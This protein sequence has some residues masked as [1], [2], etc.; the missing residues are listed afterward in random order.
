M[1]ATPPTNIRPYSLYNHLDVHGNISDLNGN[2]QQWNM[3]YSTLFG[4]KY[5]QLGSELV[6]GVAIE[7]GLIPIGIGGFNYVFG[8]SINAFGDIV[9]LATANQLSSQSIVKIY[10]WDG[11]EWKQRGVDIVGQTAGDATGFSVSL[12]DAGDRVAVGAIYAGA[13]G[14]SRVYSWNGTSWT[15]SGVDIPGEANDD[16]SGWSVMLNGSGN[17]L[18]VGAYANS[19]G[20]IGVDTGHV[21]VY[22][23]NGTSWT[24]IGSDID[25]KIIGEY[26]GYEVSFNTAGDTLAVGSP[27][28]N[29]ETGLVRI[30][31]YDGAEW[32]QFGADIIGENAAE[33]AGISVSLN[34]LG[35]RVAIGSGY[36][37]A[38]DRGSVSIY[39]WRETAWVKVG[40]DIAGI[41]A[42]GASGWRVSL[43]ALGDRV[44]IG[45]PWENISGSTPRGEI[46][47]YQWDENSWTNVET[48]TGEANETEFGYSLKSNAAG[49][50]IVCHSAN[51]VKV[52]TN[53]HKLLAYK[54]SSNLTG[55]T[56]YVDSISGSDSR[57]NT[58]PYNEHKP[59]KTIAAAI[60][61][62]T[63][64]D[65]VRVRAGSY[66]ISSSISL[67]DKSNYIYFE[68]GAAVT[69][70]STTSTDTITAAAFTCTAAATEIKNIQGHATF[71]LVGTT[72]LPKLVWLEASGSNNPVMNFQ[73]GSITSTVAVSSVFA[74]KNAT[75]L[76]VDIQGVGANSLGVNL[77]SA[78][79]VLFSVTGTSTLVVNAKWIS[80]GK[81]LKNAAI[82]GATQ[83]SNI[84]SYIQIL[85]T[86][87]TTSGIDI[88]ALSNA[89]FYITRYYH[90]GTGVACIWGND[91]IVEK[92]S[93]HDTL[94][95]TRDANKNH[96]SI[97]PS[98]GVTSLS[99]K[100][101]KLL[102]THTMT[103]ATGTTTANSIFSSLPL[104]IWTQNTYAATAAN[105]NITFKVGMFTVDTD[106]QSFN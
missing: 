71:T 51:S 103:S 86:S 19:A 28:A 79:S 27:T 53:S 16:Y 33:L 60:A 13:S 34:S 21:R 44:V 49:D 101:I 63:T 76:Y 12:N 104:N 97:F 93:F 73:C 92:I 25:G 50:T 95:A 80:C 56:I 9:A 47:I 4:S 102:G 99:S 1:P 58:V 96:I 94:W 46:R 69:V 62:S 39:E 30:Y 20:G 83:A 100:K 90:T 78:S 2:S 23:Y 98:G 61:A 45:A 38:D 64:S 5:T 11:R 89:E 35:D 105:A 106:T 18:A 75:R 42:G 82:A 15:Q 3:T 72:T 29:G 88:S 40:S 37:F 91:S 65:S 26:S 68:P 6:Y 70:T 48:I 32:V 8:S 31:K 59:Y 81:Y 14:E 24:Q 84:Y 57:I 10:K 17:R 41:D 66:T 87:N 36:D 74:I 55:R 7:E 77:T 54:W 22:E 85:N 43:N 52:I 67:N